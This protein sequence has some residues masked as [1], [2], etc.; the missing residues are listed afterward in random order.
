MS[1]KEKVD[2]ETTGEWNFLFGDNK[3]V[4]VSTNGWQ[5]RAAGIKVSFV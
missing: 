2:H 4:K 1:A 5:F 3:P